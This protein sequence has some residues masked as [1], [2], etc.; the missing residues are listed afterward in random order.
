MKN[1]NA[2]ALKLIGMIMIVFGLI[3]AVVG[4]LALMGTL[5]NVLPGHETQEVLVVVLAYA[6]ALF[7]IVCGIACVKNS[8]AVAKV[9][10]AIIA[11]VALASL[12]YLQFTQNTFSIVT[13]WQLAS[14][15]PFT[16][17]HLKNKRMTIK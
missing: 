9:L 10:G 8:T 11:V 4:T 6:V 1:S 14:A 7:A 3:Y 17:L 12:L 2:T 13:A 5:N 16:V 15:F